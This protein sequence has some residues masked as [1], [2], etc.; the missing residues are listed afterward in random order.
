M[1]QKTPKTKE[2]ILH[3]SQFE[4][5][6]FKEQFCAAI[7]GVRGGKTYVGS[8]WAG[9]KIQECK[10]N[11]LIVGPDYK[12][13]QS[14]TLPTFFSLFPQYRKY[15]KQQKSV[16]EFPNGKMVFIRSME[17]PLSPEGITAEWFWA[18]EAGKYKL[19]AWTVLRSRVSLNKGQGFLTTTPYNMGWLYE[20]FYKPWE[21]N[22]DPDYK[23]VT[24]ASVD[25]PYFPQEVFDAEKR[26]LKPAE[27]KRRYMGEFARMQ[28]LVYD[29]KPI[30]IIDP[31]EIPQSEV[32][33][34][35]IDWGWT[36]P[37]A[38][39]IIKII[40]NKY[41]I[42][43]EWYE[44]GKTTGQL[45]DKAIEL[46]DKW[47]VNRWYADSANPEKIAEA[48]ENTG[49]N[50]IGF[51]KKK[52]SLTAGVSWINTLMLDNQ[53]VVFRGL[54]NIISEFETYQYPE[55]DDSGIIK[56]DEP[57]PFNN[58]L[59]DAM[60]YAIMGFQPAKRARTPKPTQESFTSIN[61]RRL[62]NESDQQQSG[63]E[64][65]YI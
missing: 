44:V 12:T 34:G 11:G 61:V 24:W 43:D 9:K 54:K 35:G 4:A 65:D 26:R 33:L 28:G 41:Y 25:N 60:R 21:E 58:H 46:Q 6:N 13:L 52:D 8:A 15:Y 23:V 2:I 50:V 37:A 64:D 27:F 45:I 7:A 40:D 47:G 63:G 56:K 30:H 17:D 3:D 38:L 31:K 29:L 19:L 53:L 51:E 48:K 5:F 57:M 62:L 1:S 49:L 20:Q 42:V 10:G 39:V 59:M 55:P 32:T 18:D 22:T 14:A 36:N 16:L